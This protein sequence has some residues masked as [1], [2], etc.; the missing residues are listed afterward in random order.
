M[1]LEELTTNPA[2]WIWQ[3]PPGAT[4]YFPPAKEWYKVDREQ[5]FIW[6]KVERRWRPRN[7]NGVIK[8]RLPRSIQRPAE[9]VNGFPPEGTICR[10][11]TTYGN[12]APH[13]TWCE[14]IGI[15]EGRAWWFERDSDNRRYVRADSVERTTGIFRPNRN[16]RDQWIENALTITGGECNPSGA[17]LLYDA[18]IDGH[19]SIPNRP[20]PV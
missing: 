1:N 3:A 10:V 5:V 12:K 6:F 11:N 19:L 15:R 9:W 17:E 8:D 13:Y 14:F 18:M 7:P 20:E 2:Y 4:H 16:A